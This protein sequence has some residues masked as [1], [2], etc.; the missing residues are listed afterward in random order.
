MN[1]L[2]W[3]L[4]QD[5]APVDLIPLQ[6]PAEALASLDALSRWLPGGA[7]TTLRTFAGLKALALPDHLARL[8]ETARLAGHPLDLDPERIRAGL[9]LAL[10]AGL[11]PGVPAGAPPDRRL[12]I[13]ID[14]EAQLGTVYLSSEPLRLLPRPA[15]A[16]G[17]RVVHTELERRLPKAKLTRFIESSGPVRRALPAEVNE[18]VMVDADGCLLEGLTSNFFAVRDGV[19]WTAEQG[20]LSGIT[21]QVTL[22]CAGELG[23]PVALQPLPLQA[24]PLI[25]EAFITS[26]SRGVLPVRQFDEWQIGPA[27]PGPWTARLMAAYEQRVEQL[28][29]LI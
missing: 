9:R 3:K 22:A 20:V 23:L 13:T 2:C 29:E 1:L 6:A 28:V 18:A 10:A 16:H 25:T 11:P 26:A 4:T 12:R 19:L 14:L 15:Y 21:R 7:Y 8:A 5:P 27:C 17:V 24:V